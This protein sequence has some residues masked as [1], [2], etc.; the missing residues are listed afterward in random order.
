MDKAHTDRTSSNNLAIDEMF[1]DNP[2]N[3]MMELDEVFVMF[4]FSKSSNGQYLTFLL[5][6]SLRFV[7][8]VVVYSQYRRPVSVASVSRWPWAA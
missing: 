1:P 3:I 5:F 8:V 4:F 2:A 7:F 6:F